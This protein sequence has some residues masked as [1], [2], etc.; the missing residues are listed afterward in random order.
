MILTL[1]LIFSASIIIISVLA[2]I[3]YTQENSYRDNDRNREE[4]NE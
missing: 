1:V 3:C 4:N 2:K